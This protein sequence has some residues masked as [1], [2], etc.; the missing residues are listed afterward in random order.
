VSVHPNTPRLWDRKSILVAVRI[1]ERKI[2]WYLLEDIKRYIK[3][4]NMKKDHSIALFNQK[5]VRRLWDENDEFWYFSII[6]V[7]KFLTGSTIP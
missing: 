1:G 2:K 7:I 3:R 4:N 6:D 5:K